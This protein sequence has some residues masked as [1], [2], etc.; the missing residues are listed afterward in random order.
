MSKFSKIP[1]TDRS[2][3]SVGLLVAWSVGWS[4]FWSIRPPQNISGPVLG[5]VLVEMLNEDSRSLVMKNKHI[6]EQHQ[7]P[8]IKKITIKNMKSKELHFAENLGNNLLQKIPGCEN[9]FVA[10]NGQIRERTR[11]H[12]HRT[13]NQFHQS[14]NQSYMP[15]SYQPYQ[16][17]FATAQQQPFQMVQQPAYQQTP[18]QAFRGQQQQSRKRRRRQDFLMSKIRMS[19]F[20]AQKLRIHERIMKRGVI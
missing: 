6:L 17:H 4:V 8:S 10:Q 16:Q 18:H 19:S 3:Q 12:P 13:S 14:Y 1:M 7:D 5:T 15:Q 11:A 2:T 9:L 20:I